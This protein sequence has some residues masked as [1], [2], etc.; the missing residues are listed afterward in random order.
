MSANMLKIMRPA[1]KR[2]RRGLT[3]IEAA[4]VLVIL[5]LVVGAVMLYY[6]GANSSRQVS[7]VSTPSA[8]TRSPSE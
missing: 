7:A 1:A 8:T 2:I 4:M 6:Q 3:L 5:A